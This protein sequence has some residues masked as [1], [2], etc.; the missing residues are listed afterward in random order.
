MGYLLL[1]QPY[2]RKQI[3]GIQNIAGTVSGIVSVDL[4]ELIDND[5]E[6]L[7][8]ICESRLIAEGVLSDITYKV[9]GTSLN[10]SIHLYVDGE[11]ELF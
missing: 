1:E 8:D 10:N 7:M 2:N 6:G 5:F 11:V 9:V 4:H 3:E